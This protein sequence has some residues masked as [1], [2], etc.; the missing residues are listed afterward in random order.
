M[1][2]KRTHLMMLAVTFGLYAI[3]SFG[4]TLLLQYANTDIVL[5]ASVLP[6]ALAILIE[7]TEILI[8]AFG[9]SLMIGASFSGFSLPSVLGLG[10]I[11]SCACIFRRLCD[12]A[13]ILIVFQELGIEDLIESTTYLLLD[14]ILIW[15]ILWLIRWQ[16][17]RYA[18]KKSD[19]IKGS[20]LFSSD[21]PSPS[22]LSDFFPFQRIYSKKNPAQTCILCIAVIRSAVK[23]ISR[24]IYDIDYGAPE[25]FGE[26]VTM[27]VY[28]CSDLLIGVIFYALA[29]LFL[30]K[31]FR[32]FTPSNQ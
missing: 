15:I 3:L 19:L 16:L 20:A 14:L 13:V 32:R 7:L 25:G 5:Y 1:K 9:F 2:T 29:T 4:F 24:I 30:G 21:S 12:L 31:F 28:Y 22:D 8:Y 17:A 10:G 18:R 23:I 26:V 27:A 11:L 6:E